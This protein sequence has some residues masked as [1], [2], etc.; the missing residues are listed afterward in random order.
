MVAF[1]VAQLGFQAASAILVCYRKEILLL[2]AMAPACLLGVTHL[3]GGYDDTLTVPTLVAGGLSVALALAVAWHTAL[4]APTRPDPPRMTPARQLAR[5]VLPGTA[6]AAVSAFFLLYNDSRYVQ[7]P[8]D[9]ALSVTPLVLGMGALEWRSHRFDART[10]KLLRHAESTAEFRRE[11]WRALLRELT[12]CLLV[13]AGF[14][15]VL[16]LVLGASGVLTSRG[17]LLVDAH[18]VLGGIGLGAE[19]G[20]DRAVHGDAAGDDQRFRGAARGDPRVGKQLRETHARK[21]GTSIERWTSSCSA[22]GWTL[23]AS[24][25][26]ASAR[27]GNGRRAAPP[28]TPR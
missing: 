20:H 7:A 18:V 27:S 2:A 11:T 9:L 19:L 22:I 16:L 12:L 4:R 15:V 14:A 6:Y 21:R 8:I 28:R 26:S 17:A 10:R 25:A 13:L 23:W 5:V 3:L 1:T 24:P